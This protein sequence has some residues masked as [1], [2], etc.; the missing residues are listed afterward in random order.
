MGNEGSLLLSAFGM[1]PGPAAQKTLH[2]TEGTQRRID[3]RVAGAHPPPE[4][5]WEGPTRG[6]VEGELDR[7][8][9]YVRVEEGREEEGF[10][11][12]L[13]VIDQVHR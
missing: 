1:Q 6:A 5:R 2:L 4:V 13:T 8:K 3:C 9:K 10:R 12:N 7:V 11:G